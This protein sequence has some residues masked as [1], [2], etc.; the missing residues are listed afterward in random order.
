LNALAQWLGRAA[1]RAGIAFMKSLAFLPLSW[2][3]ALG[4]GLGWVLYRLIGARRRVVLANLSACFPDLSEAQRRKL[5]RETFVCFSQAWL[6]RAWLW[7]GPKAWV[8]RRVRLT[9]AVH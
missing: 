4:T 2:V 6:D 9:C 1:T 3:R 7:H 8:Q 5:A